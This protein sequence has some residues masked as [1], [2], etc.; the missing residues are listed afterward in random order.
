MSY[1]V[2]NRTGF[3][4]GVIPN[5]VAELRRVL[6]PHIFQYFLYERRTVGKAGEATRTRRP[7]VASGQHVCPG[8]TR[9]RSVSI[10]GSLKTGFGF[11]IEHHI[12]W[13][14]DDDFLRA[15]KQAIQPARRSDA[16]H[17][18]TQAE[19]HKALGWQRLQ[20]WPRRAKP[21]GSNPG[22]IRDSYSVPRIF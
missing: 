18:Q 20:P 13:P 8:N 15:G 5:D 17:P 7:V 11:G 12:K 19:E 4:A 10:N 14:I 22:S 21:V 9:Q 1:S 2:D 6:V 16:A 3:F